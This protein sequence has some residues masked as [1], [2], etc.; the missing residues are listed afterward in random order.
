MPAGGGR[1]GTAGADPAHL[2]AWF[3]ECYGEPPELIWHAPGRVNLI[4]EH[5]D[6]NEGLVLP[7]AIDRG[8]L[9]AGAPRPDDVLEL[10]SRQMP[11]QV[12]AIRLDQLRPG[13]VAGWAGYAAGAAWALR[14]AGSPVRGMRL[15]I[16]SDLPIGAGLASSAALSCAVL[17][18]LAALSGA[19]RRPSRTES[20]AL[21]RSA[22]ADFVGMPCGIMDQ[23][24]SMLCQ[25]GHALL[26]DCKTGRTTPVPFD[27]DD[28]GLRMVVFDTGIRHVLADGQYAARR[29]ECEQAARRL[30]IRSLRDITDAGQLARLS[31]PLLQRR[32][33]HVVTENQR[34]QRAA[35]LLRA[36]LLADCGELLTASHI[37]L[38]DDFEVSWH[39]ADATV[40]A[41]LAAGALG[42]R[43]TGGG[44]GGSVLVLV[45]VGLAGEVTASVGRA[46]PA[47]TAALA[48]HA[49][50]VPF[51]IAVR[52]SA[53]ARQV[54]PAT[55][56]R[57]RAGSRPG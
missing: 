1:A 6:Y 43:M 31:D 4:G 48:G 16:D 29:Q 39:A 24:A 42:A 41:A 3:G 40:E 8:V 15:G 33:R 56:A 25:E 36:G 17:S 21:A 50:T 49:G 34:V 5:T 19:V 37:S 54:W 28:A 45:P 32:A 2:A 7:F 9:A 20:A 53:G 30:G 23:S 44:F 26:L 22:E 55:P 47:R 14:E 10:R 35:A 57:P 52:P 11:G 27:P 46:L 38:R 18:C 13:A 12:T 51:C